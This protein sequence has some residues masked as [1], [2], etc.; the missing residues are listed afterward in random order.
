MKIIIAIATVL[1]MVTP[2]AYADEQLDGPDYGIGQPGPPE[3]EVSAFDIGPAGNGNIFAPGFNRTGAWNIYKDT[4]NKL[5]NTIHFA[6][7]DGGGWGGLQR[8]KITIQTTTG[9][10]VNYTF[11]PRSGDYVGCIK[12]TTWRGYRGVQLNGGQYAKTIKVKMIS[13][14]GGAIQWMWLYMNTTASGDA[15]WRRT[16][17]QYRDACYW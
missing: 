6:D 16:P 2:I 3:G 4:N 7:V 11:K 15:G 13:N 9:D 14:T 10:V 12:Q 1:L 5:T 8:Y 17:T